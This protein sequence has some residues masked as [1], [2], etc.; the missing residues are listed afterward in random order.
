MEHEEKVWD[1][2][3]K[4]K[5]VFDIVWKW[6]QSEDDSGG[7]ALAIPK[8]VGYYWEKRIL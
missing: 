5:L 8:A 1:P 4:T 2:G 7:A 3:G 6:G